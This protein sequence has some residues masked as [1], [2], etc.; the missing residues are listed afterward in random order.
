MFEISKQD[1]FYKIELNDEHLELIQYAL[2]WMSYSEHVDGN[3]YNSNP[4]EGEINLEMIEKI[5]NARVIR[6]MFYKLL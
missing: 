6:Y 1:N 4:R 3:M 5:S 2:N